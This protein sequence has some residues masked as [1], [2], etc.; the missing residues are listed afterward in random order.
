MSWKWWPRFRNRVLPWFGLA[1][2]M[3]LIAIAVY[4]AWPNAKRKQ[5]LAI[6]AGNL[7]GTR[8][9]IAQ[10]LKDGIASSEN[11]H[12]KL[13]VV[14]SAGSSDAL[15]K[16][17]AGE[18][19]LALI[20]G[21]LDERYA[22]VRRIAALHVE[23][24]HLLVCAQAYEDVSL[25]LSAL[26]GQTINLSTEGSGTN[27]LASDLLSFLNLQQAKDYQPAHLTY[28][29]L[30]N[31]EPEDTLP[32]AVFTVSSLPSPVATYLIRERGYRL[33]ELP[34]AQSFR[35]RWFEAQETDAH[36][37]RARVSATTI[38]AFIYQAD[39]PRPEKP[40]LTFGT[41][42]ELVANASLSNETIDQICEV[43]YETEFSSMFDEKLDP[44]ILRTESTFALHPGSKQYVDRLQP[45]STGRVIE[46]T[47]QLVGIFGA[48]LGGLLFLW[49]WLKRARE[50][51][52]DKEF[53]TCV[54]RVVEIENQALRFEQDP[55]M[56]VA[57]LEEM[58]N[59]LGNIKTELIQR[60]RDGHLEGADMLSAFLKHANDASE[61]I[62]RIVLHEVK[63]KS[64][65]T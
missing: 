55:E 40:V 32:H 19:Q 51:R 23:P 43:V 11:A 16:V 36:V 37:N 35:M 58:Q 31:S 20:Q 8:A 61:L 26:Q 53:V 10:L 5:T 49:Q 17:D 2:A 38:P 14:D 13:E 57:D 9:N 3:F 12:L 28:N 65:Q 62:S 21:G 42:L 46:V 56:S 33:V 6:S 22:N 54:Q 29:E 48:A 25:H 63:P 50:Q 4:Y 47:E 7:L 45:V 64:E 52:R 1:A 41:R 59:E 24:L 39:P 15:Q 60:Y 44:S 18:L 34:F 27:Q 30:M